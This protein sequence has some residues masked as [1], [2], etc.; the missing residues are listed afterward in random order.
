MRRARLITHRFW[1]IALLSLATGCGWRSPEVAPLTIQVYQDWQL[2]YG[3]EIGGYQ[4]QGGLG[5]I[6]LDLRGDR[7]H[8]PFNGEVFPAESPA[9]GCVYVSSAEVPAYLFRICGLSRPRLGPL[10]AGQNLGRG[11]LLVFST[12][13]KQPDGTWAL[14]EPAPDLIESWVRSPAP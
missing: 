14:V 1:L 10:T 2:S 12:L 9:S 5:D 13:R 3:D 7:I 6:A 8:M 4:V 11:Q